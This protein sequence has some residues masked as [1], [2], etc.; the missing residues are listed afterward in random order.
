MWVKHSREGR[1]SGVQL[2]FLVENFL[3]LTAFLIS[4]VTM[5]HTFPIKHFNEF[6][7]YASLLK[8]QTFGMNTFKTTFY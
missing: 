2:L 6:K 3:I 7:P 1:L 4:S 5:F 8:A